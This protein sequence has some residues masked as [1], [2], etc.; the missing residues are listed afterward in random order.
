MQPNGCLRP[1]LGAQPTLVNALAALPVADFAVKIIP[2]I[3]DRRQH[4]IKGYSLPNF[5]G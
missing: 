2:C 5:T 3:G 4:E 1:P